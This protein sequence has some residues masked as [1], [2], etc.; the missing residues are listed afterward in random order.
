MLLAAIAA[1]VLAIGVPSVPAAGASGEVAIT[2]VS[3]HLTRPTPTTMVIVG[4]VRN[5][6]SQ[7]VNAIVTVSL[8]ADPFAIATNVLTPNLAPGA[9]GPFLYTKTW[10]VAPANTPTITEITATGLTGTPSP[11]A[12]IGAVQIS[13]V[14]NLGPPDPDTAVQVEVHNRTGQAVHVD[15][16]IGT[17]YDTQ[18]LVVATGST[19][20]DADLGAGDAIEVWV[21]GTGT[22]AALNVLI[23][24]DARPVGG[25]MH[26]VVAWT[27]WFHDLGSSAFVRD[28]AWLAD[29]GITVG[30]TPTTFCPR[31]DVT[32]AEMASFLR[33]ALDLPAT[34]TDYF[35]D[36]ESSTHEDSINRLRAAGITSGCTSTKFC[37]SDPVSR[38]QMAS[39]L[40][41]AFDLPPAAEDYFTDDES[42]THE[43]SINRLRA[44]LITFG[45]TP[46]TFCP[47][48]SVTREQMAAFLRRAME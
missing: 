36:D 12:A 30:C 28:I 5:T 29:N 45:C 41:R 7:R 14:F 18:G 13:K 32:R 15:A 39:F 33:R 37:P 31:G 16:V 44:A 35:S 48:A 47:N 46:D 11:V 17:F 24:V 20:V 2:V 19:T 4:E 8:D 26:T 27:N 34:A 21:N 38:G 22:S 9:K 1:S 40:R 6:S 42:S 10:A 25:A 3:Y 43:D 23:G